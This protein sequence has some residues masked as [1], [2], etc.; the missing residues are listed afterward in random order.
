MQP[1]YLPYLG[2]FQLMA[3]VDEYVVLNDVQFAKP[4][5]QMRN[6]IRT[7]YHY[8]KAL[9]DTVG[10]V[11]LTV[12]TKY[13][14][15]GSAERM[16]FNV[17]IDYPTMWN[18][19]HMDTIIHYYKKAPFFDEVLPL[20][21]D[22]INRPWSRLY[23]LNLTLINNMRDY[24]EVKTPMTIDSALPYDREVS[25]SKRL[26]NL[27]EAMGGDV[28]VEPEGGKKFLEVEP[29]EERGIEVYFQKFFPYGYKQLWDGPFVSHMSALDA[30][31][32][33]GKV[34]KNLIKD[35]EVVKA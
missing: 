14:Q 34:A 21:G 2:F 35:M 24:L 18:L 1:T 30:M 11:W 10:W 28:Y 9:K 22:V 6:R 33:M 5:W 3:N 17:L 31:F 27:V 26:A 29:F 7:P 32:C 13:A 20:F 15:Q 19:D 4:S 23:G 8:N 12:P 25:K 16:L